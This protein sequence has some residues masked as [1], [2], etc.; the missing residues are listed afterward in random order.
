M[1]RNV[2]HS[3]FTS[4]HLIETTGSQVVHIVNEDKR[5]WL[6]IVL[7][8]NSANSNGL[9]AFFEAADLFP[10]VYRGEEILAQFWGVPEAIRVYR[11]DEERKAY[12]HLP[13]HPAPG[14]HIGLN[15]QRQVATVIEDPRRTFDFSSVPQVPE[16]IL[17]QLITE[18][19]ND[20]RKLSHFALTRILGALATPQSIALHQEAEAA[21]IL[22][23]QRIMDTAGSQDFSF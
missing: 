17:D 8:S 6:G 1:A 7:R 14:S 16:E 19:E 13:G 15:S 9:V 18:T 10:A 22:R 20:M 23:R 21:R 11:R 2:I 4:E 12:V 5:S 3:D